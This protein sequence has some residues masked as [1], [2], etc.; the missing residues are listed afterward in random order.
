MA[1]PTVLQLEV[2]TDEATDLADVLRNKATAIL[3][4]AAKCRDTS[5]LGGYYDKAGRLYLLANA[6][7]EQVGA[8]NS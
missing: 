7:M 5:V 4:D 2:T 8:D 1:T 3:N 6:I